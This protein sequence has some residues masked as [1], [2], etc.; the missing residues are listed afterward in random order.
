MRQ[1]G[2]VVARIAPTPSGYLHTGNALNFVFNALAARVAPQGRL[3]LRIDDLD[4]ERKRPE[5]V[6][7]IFRCLEWLG[8]EWQEGPQGPDELEARWSQQHRMPQ[9]MAALETLRQ[10]GMVFACGKSRKAL[11]PFG[12]DYP[13]AFRR[14]GLSLDDPDVAWRA[15]T[16][17]HFPLPCF[18]VRQ[19]QGRPSYQVASV[20]DDV[21]FGVTHLIRGED[22]APSSAAQ[23]WLCDYIGC[24]SFH[25]TLTFH[26]GLIKDANGAK[27]SKTDGAPAL[28]ARYAQNR[29][30]VAI[31]QLAANWLGI[32]A[33]DIE[34]LDDLVAF[35]L[36]T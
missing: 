32:E 9:Y 30:S 23:Y 26:H 17:A 29:S 3:L 18:V 35:L 6:E 5:Y 31:Y 19:R 20:C 28:R 33:K 14:Q 4:A 16:P 27:L 36:A 2:A 1:A 11:A 22:L 24:A 15:Q 10:S 21:N 34:T 25:Q 7:D 12:E 8:I 13:D